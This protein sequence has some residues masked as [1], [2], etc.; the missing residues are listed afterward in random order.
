M[1][2]AACLRKMA[3]SAS[4]RNRRA[5]GTH[6]CFFTANSRRALR[7]EHNLPVRPDLLRRAKRLLN[8]VEL[9]HARHGNAEF[10]VRCFFGKFLEARG[11]RL[12]HDGFL[13]H[14]SIGHAG[15]DFRDAGFRTCDRAVAGGDRRSA[16]H[17]TGCQAAPEANGARHGRSGQRGAQRG[18]RGAKHGARVT[19]GV[20]RREKKRRRAYW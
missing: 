6:G 3:P 9:H 18:S 12:R 14:M 2:A 16:A 11:I 5:R 7:R 10:A 8:F 15:A 1:V 20:R 17:R 4:T 19:A 13:A